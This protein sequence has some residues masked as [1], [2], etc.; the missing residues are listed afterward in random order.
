[1]QPACYRISLVFA[2]RVVSSQIFC[3]AKSQRRPVVVSMSVEASQR[4]RL[5][6]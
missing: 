4:P 3:A 6:K 2:Q 5:F 1:M